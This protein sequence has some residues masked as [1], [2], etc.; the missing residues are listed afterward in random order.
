LDIFSNT[1]KS[2]YSKIAPEEEIDEFGTRI[3]DFSKYENQEQG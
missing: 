2:K 1:S 3:F